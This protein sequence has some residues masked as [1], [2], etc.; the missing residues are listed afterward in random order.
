VLAF[1]GIFSIERAAVP[2]K[3][4]LSSIIVQMMEA[5]YGLEIA[6]ALNYLE[7]IMGFVSEARN[8]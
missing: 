5:I 1:P 4:T 2:L 6:G 8:Y 3:A 7:N